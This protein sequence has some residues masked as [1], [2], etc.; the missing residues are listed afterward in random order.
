LCSAPA[1]RPPPPR[2][3]VFMWF[4]PERCN[5]DTNELLSFERIRPE[6]GAKKANLKKSK[7]MILQFQ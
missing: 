4:I 6:I 7:E 2:L 3:P 5:K 1:A